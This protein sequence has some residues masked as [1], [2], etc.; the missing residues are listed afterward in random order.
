MLDIIKEIVNND[1]TLNRGKKMERLS[2]H[3]SLVLFRVISLVM[4]NI[5]KLIR[6]KVYEKR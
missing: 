6:R 4:E 1:N 5:F 3:Y 2:D